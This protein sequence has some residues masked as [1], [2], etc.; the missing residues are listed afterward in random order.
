MKPHLTSLLCLALTALASSQASAS[1]TDLQS[2]YLARQPAALEARAREM[3][4]RD[5]LDDAALWHWGRQ[6]AGDAK[7]RAELMPRARQCVQSRPE[8]ARCQHLLGVLIGAELTEMGGFAA[9][10]R[11]GEVRDQFERAVALAPQDYAMRRD[12]VGYYL[13]VPGFM[14]GSNRKARELA[15]SMGR[16]D[17]PRGVLL[18]AIVAI[19]TKAFD[20]AQQLLGGV[21]PGNDRQLA[22]DLLGVQVDLARAWREAGNAERARA[23]AERLAQQDARSPEIRVELGQALLVLNQPAAAASAFEQALQ[24]DASQRIHHLLAGAREAVGDRAGAIAA[25]RAELASPSSHATA[26]KA[27]ERLK[28]LQP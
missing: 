19:G 26:E 8:S 27:R 15:D 3:L 28:A 24:L 10:R 25:Y 14:G 12:L 1:E 4:A 11:V 6:A 16:T 21:T 22:R 13:A 2:A 5:P 20:S 7:L 18:Q 23:W 17:A 9:M